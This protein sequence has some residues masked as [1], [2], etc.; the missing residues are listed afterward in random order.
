MISRI[1]LILP[2]RTIP[3]P[4]N[5]LCARRTLILGRIPTAQRVKP[6]SRLASIR[7][8]LTDSS[9]LIGSTLLVTFGVVTI[10]SISAILIPEL[11]SFRTSETY[12]YDLALA[13]VSI[14]TVLIEL[15]QA[16][17]FSF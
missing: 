4:I 2:R 16:I 12:A 14:N 5:P 10:I 17:Y 1:I 15:I 13:H 8:T 3:V 9:T 6:R 7:H 11:F